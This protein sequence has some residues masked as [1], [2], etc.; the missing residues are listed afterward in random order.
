MN[1]REKVVNHWVFVSTSTLIGIGSFGFFLAYYLLVEPLRDEVEKL[2][3][4]NSQLH[5]RLDEASRRSTKETIIP[6]PTPP[7]AEATSSPPKGGE[8]VDGAKK[9]SSVPMDQR[10]FIEHTI[11]SYAD[12]WEARRMELTALE[13][14]KF[15]ETLK[16]RWVVWKGRVDFI[17]DFSDSVKIRIWGSP[18][19]G[20]EI[21]FTGDEMKDVLLLRPGDHVRVGGRIAYPNSSPIIESAWLVK[22][23]SSR[24][25]E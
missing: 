3:R 18:G 9:E 22:V 4:A 5:Y 23:F 20:A 17:A 16:D 19:G 24:P 11:S 10:K 25:S 15:K 2:E 21:F 1:L 12:L 7:S 14:G 6:T 13:F 8:D